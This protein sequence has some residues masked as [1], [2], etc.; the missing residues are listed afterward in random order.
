MQR[1]DLPASG[2]QHD[3]SEQE[4]VDEQAALGRPVAFAD[5]IGV[6][7]EPPDGHR[8]AS[9]GLRLFARQVGDAFKLPDEPVVR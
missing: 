4:A 1:G 6:F 5:H 7:I 8:Q 2:L 3:V 9:Q